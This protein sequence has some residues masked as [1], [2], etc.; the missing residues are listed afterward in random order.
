MRSFVA[1]KCV[2]D[3]PTEILHRSVHADKALIPASVSVVSVPQRFNSAFANPN[4]GI[5]V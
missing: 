4:L 5:R 3:L 2:Q 1:M